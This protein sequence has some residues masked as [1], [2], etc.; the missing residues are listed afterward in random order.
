MPSLTKSVLLP[1]P[2]SAMFD[3]VERV[4]DYPDFLPWCPSTE[5][6]RIEGGMIATVGIRFKGIRQSFT[7]RNTHVRP[8]SIDMDLV[9][10]PFRRLQGRWRFHELAPQACKVEFTIDYEI[11]GGLLGRALSPVFGQIASTFVDAFV[12]RAAVIHHQGAA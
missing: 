5:V 12:K 4:E 3:L 2:A 6:E 7:T 1:Y 10:G 9:N 8:T 11:A